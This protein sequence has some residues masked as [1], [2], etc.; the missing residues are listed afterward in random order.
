[1]QQA[2][3]ITARAKR[4]QKKEAQ[5]SR[6]ATFCGRCGVDLKVRTGMCRRCADYL[7]LPTPKRLP[8]PEQLKTKAKKDLQQR[9]EENRRA[10]LARVV[11]QRKAADAK[12]RDQTFPRASDVTITRPD[13]TVEIKPAYKTPLELHKVAPEREPIPGHLRR[14]VLARDGNACRYCGNMDGPF[15]MDHVMPVSKGG[16]TNQGNLVTACETCNLR[17]GAEYWRPNP[18][19]RRLRA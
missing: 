12:R 8:T 18:L 2:Q 4:R 10:Y 9:E 13:G 15:H 11:P 3:Y 19:P 1:M 6:L 14:R 7:G 17:K 16:P 5:V